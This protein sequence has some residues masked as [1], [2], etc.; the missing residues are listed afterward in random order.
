MLKKNNKIIK[1]RIFFHFKIK[2]INLFLTYIL[3]IILLFSKNFLIFGSFLM[4][5]INVFSSKSFCILITDLFFPLIC[6][7]ILTS[8]FEIY[9]LFIDFGHSS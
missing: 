9:S 7:T 5:I 6:I 1:I 3:L 8:L 4:A 2:L